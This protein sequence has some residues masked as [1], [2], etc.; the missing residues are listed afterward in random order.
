MGQAIPT[1]P[2][3]ADDVYKAGRGV[4]DLS[5]KD[6]GGLGN[7]FALRALCVSGLPVDNLFVNDGCFFLFVSCRAEMMCA[8][9]ALDLFVI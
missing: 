7:V 8:L 3:C 2:L 6:S 4:Q 9:S 5:R 1:S